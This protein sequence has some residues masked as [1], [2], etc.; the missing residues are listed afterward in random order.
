MRHEQTDPK[1]MHVEN[2]KARL[3]RA[4]YVVDPEAVAEAMLRRAGLGGLH[5]ANQPAV[6]PRARSPRAGARPQ[7]RRS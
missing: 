3:A 6:R 7:R 5:T 2:L 1:A 4:D